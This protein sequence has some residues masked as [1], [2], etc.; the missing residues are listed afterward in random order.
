MNLKIFTNASTK[1]KMI[2]ADYH[3]WTVEEALTNVDRIVDR[4]RM[5]GKQIEAKFITGHGQIQREIL[6]SLKHYGLEPTIQLSN[7]GVVLVV[8]E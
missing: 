7:S 2:T 3:G 1:C 8:I 6:S 4:V 5:E